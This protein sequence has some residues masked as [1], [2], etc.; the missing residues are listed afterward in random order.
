MLQTLMFPNQDHG[1]MSVSE[2]GTLTIE[3]VH[4][5]DAG[6]YICKGLSIAG[7]AYAKARLDVKGQSLLVGL[8][9]SSPH[10][11]LSADS[12]AW[13]PGGPVGPPSRWAATS[14]VE[15]GQINRR[16]G[17]ES[18]LGTKSQRGGE[19]RR[20]WNRGGGPYFRTEGFIR[21]FVYGPPSS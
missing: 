17:R 12:V 19:G 6:Q 3:P 10:L 8:V 1:R 9:G 16:E 20:E 15:V 2:D 14:N 7:S 13:S 21:I 11:C 18:E 5:Q 4:R